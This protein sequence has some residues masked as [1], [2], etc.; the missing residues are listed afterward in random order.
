MR[1]H[2]IAL[3]VLFCASS[4]TRLLD[5]MNDRSG[6]LRVYQPLICELKAVVF[7]GG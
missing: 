3:L 7:D 5:I 4:N 1:V 2:F 6:I